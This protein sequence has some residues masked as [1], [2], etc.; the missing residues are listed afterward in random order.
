MKSQRSAITA[1][2]N[3]NRHTIAARGSPM[4]M[5]RRISNRVTYSIT[6]ASSDEEGSALAKIALRSARMAW[7]CDMEIPS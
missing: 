5:I 6:M 2:T 4:V 7:L 1:V 3:I